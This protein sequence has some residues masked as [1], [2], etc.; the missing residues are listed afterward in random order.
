MLREFQEMG[1]LIIEEIRG[2]KIK[3]FGRAHGSDF[4]DENG[5]FISNGILMKIF[6]EESGDL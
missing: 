1:T 5:I 4:L 2:K 6:L 3:V